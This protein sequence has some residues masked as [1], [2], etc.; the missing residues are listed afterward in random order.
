MKL[1]PNFA[2]YTCPNG[3]KSVK[4]VRPDGSFIHDKCWCEEVDVVEITKEMVT[5]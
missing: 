2:I 4:A 5:T 3:H 1:N